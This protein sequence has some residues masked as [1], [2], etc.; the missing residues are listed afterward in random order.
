MTVSLPS[1]PSSPSF[2]LL[3]NHLAVGGHEHARVGR[4]GP[5][6]LG[7]RAHGALV[8]PG[9]QVLLAIT[10][11]LDKPFAAAAAAAPAPAAA[12]REFGVARVGHAR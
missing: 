11:V 3:A 5:Q 2:G 12:A 7:V 9:H 4:P 10:G 8:P 6:R 1:S